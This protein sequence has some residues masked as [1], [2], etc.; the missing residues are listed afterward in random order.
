VQRGGKIRF[1]SAD[2]D[3]GFIHRRTCYKCGAEGRCF[4]GDFIGTFEPDNLVLTGITSIFGPAPRALLEITEQEQ[5]KAAVVSKPVLKQGERDGSVEILF[6]D[7]PGNKVRIRNG[8]LETNISFEIAK[9]PAGGP[10]SPTPLMP[11]L[12]QQAG[13]P[14]PITPTIISPSGINSAS[15][16][17]AGVS[18]YGGT[19]TAPSTPSYGMNASIPSPTSSSANQGYASVSTYGAGGASGASGLSRPLRTDPQAAPTAQEVYQRMI[20]QKRLADQAGVA[21]PPLPPSSHLG[22]AGNPPPLP[23]GAGG[24]PAFPGQK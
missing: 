16:P 4:V 7:V 10:G 23:G 15:R 19:P 11:N 12:P 14:G 21:F 24:P 22:T 2:D 3:A 13:A 8:T 1:E 18:F 6:I 20:N 5:G 9:S 17:G